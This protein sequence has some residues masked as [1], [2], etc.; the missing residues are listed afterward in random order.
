MTPRSVSTITKAEA[1]GGSTMALS[2]AAYGFLIAE[3]SP[4]PA[5]ASF[6]RYSEVSSLLHMAAS[7]PL[8]FLASLPAFG[9]LVPSKGRMRQDEAVV[10]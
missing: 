10:V 9:T 1:G 8:L 4:I 2:I 3:R 6:F 5:A 7:S